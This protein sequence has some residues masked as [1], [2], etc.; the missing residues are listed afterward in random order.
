MLIFKLFDYNIDYM[1]PIANTF[2]NICILRLSSIGDITHMIPVI[3]TI[4]HNLPKSNITWVIGKIEYSLVKDIKGI[5]FIVIDKKRTFSS[6]REMK[7]KLGSK[8]FDILLHM[9]RSLRSKIISFFINANKKFSY[10]NVNMPSNIHV[11]DSFFYFLNKI[12]IKEKILDWSLDYSLDNSISRFNLDFPEKKFL[13]INPFTSKRRSNWREWD[14]KNYLNI[15]KYAN[16]EYG[17]FTVFVGKND[18]NIDIKNKYPYI[19]NLVNK[20]NLQELSLVLN[21]CAFY[22]G[23]DSGTMHMASMHSKPIIG[24]FATSNPKR[25]G[26]YNN[27][28]YIVNKYDMALKNYIKTNEKNIKWGTRVRFKDAMSL[29]TINDVKQKIDLIMAKK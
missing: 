14:F 12:N 22:I 6:I 16:D 18:T 25:T 11:L 9:Q 26:P 29:I 4:Q 27:Q 21:N 23:P 19:L 7:S 17:L 10:E 8:K 5:E 2:E 20:T 3:K 28:K 15:S 24:L 1:P 13:V